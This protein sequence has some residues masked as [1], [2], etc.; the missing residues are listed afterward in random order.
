MP[1]KKDKSPNVRSMFTLGYSNAGSMI[2]EGSLNEKPRI[3]L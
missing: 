2:I 3:A 1:H